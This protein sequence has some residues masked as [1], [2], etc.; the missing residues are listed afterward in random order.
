MQTGTIAG[1]FI[2]WPVN[3]WLIHGMVRRCVGRRPP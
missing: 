1:F 2:A 3:T